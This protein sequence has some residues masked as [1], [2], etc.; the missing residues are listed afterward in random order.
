MA[1]NKV[2]NTQIRPREGSNTSVDWRGRQQ[3]Q[4][5]VGVAKVFGL[6]AV[7][8]VVVG[9]GIVYKDKIMALLSPPPAQIAAPTQ[10]YP[11]V[12]SI[13]APPQ[14]PVVQKV[15]EPV[16]EPVKPPVAIK[17]PDP[18]IEFDSGEDKRAQD[19]L[20]QGRKQM[21]QVV[22]HA[23]NRHLKVFDF[24]GGGRKF[25]EAATLKASPK[26][27]EEAMRWVRKAKEFSLATEHIQ[28]S[29]FAISENA[30]VITMSNGNQMRGMNMLS[31]DE[32]VFKIQTVS[33]SNPA[34]TGRSTFPIP[35][36]EITEIKPLPMEQ[37]QAG[38]KEFLTHLESGV[39]IAAD[40]PARA[41]YDLVYLSKRLGM[42]AECIEYLNRAF[43]MASDGRLA[44]EFRKL[45]ID[46]YLERATKQAV[47]GRRVQ[48]EGTLNEL[49]RMLPG[50]QTA[51]DEID[52][53][54]LKV[55]AQI[56]DGFKS[57]LVMKKAEPTSAEMAKPSAATVRQMVQEAD[58]QQPVEEI[59]G[60]DS[61]GVVGKGRAAAI[62]TKA[63]DLF[64]KGMAAY[65]KYQ[66]GTKGNNNAVLQEAAKYL[67]QAV[68]EYG[69]ALEL[70]PSNRSIE[71][72]QVEANQFLYGARKYTHL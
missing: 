56:K 64:E 45:V 21:E 44:D 43:D 60:V 37:R 65:R 13:V 58:S 49:Q 48:A 53:F 54:K 42:G 4:K 72:R 6:V 69:K 41:Y 59:V 38:F 22:A 57:T 3:K 68:D 36:N 26:V 1:E 71:D 5:I 40:A 28:I 63:N 33:E 16:R 14:P 51:R 66:P 50:Y 15:V 29:D 46:T 9:L 18:K 30:V 20:V 12:H 67:E 7:L 62:V 2:R 31:H 32:A 34:S 10:A 39:G 23:S 52:V 24:A 55:L 17:K 11:P 35:R 19:L 27:H 47:T 8:G 25:E 61:S 70:D